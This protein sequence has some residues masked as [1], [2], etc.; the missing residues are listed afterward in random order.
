MT[1]TPGVARVPD[2]RSGA[3]VE[4]PSRLASSHASPRPAD[5]AVLDEPAADPE[6][7]ARVRAAL[8]GL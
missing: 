7:L 2:M 5:H 6:L 3:P 1:A 8:L 4:L